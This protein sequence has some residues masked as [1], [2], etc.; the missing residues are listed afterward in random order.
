MRQEL[1]DHVVQ[2]GSLVAPDRLRFDFSHTKA[3]APEALARVGQSVN[4]QIQAN[5]VTTPESPEEAAEGAM[6]LFGEK[7]G[8][9][10]RVVSMG[11]QDAR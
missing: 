6:A 7:H 9:E 2:K 3:V 4:Q 5:S 1:G 8:D 11:T 10:V